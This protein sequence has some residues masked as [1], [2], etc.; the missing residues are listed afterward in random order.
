MPPSDP[1]TL[2][3]E[4]RR[5]L[6]K[7]SSD[8]ERENSCYEN[9]NAIVLLLL[10]TIIITIFMMI[11]IKITLR[12]RYTAPKKQICSHHP[13]ARPDNY[14]RHSINWFYKLPWN[15]KQCFSAQNLR[16]KK[17]NAKYLRKLEHHTN[18]LAAN[19]LDNSETTYTLTKKKKIHR[20]NST[21]E[22]WVKFQ[23]KN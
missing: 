14:L 4:A 15:T 16:T 23:Y 17:W 19:L 2:F 1:Y 11:I 18:A 22:T 13:D 9:L 8:L 12:M 10:R 21:R 3:R 5:D 7:I 20:P 6:R